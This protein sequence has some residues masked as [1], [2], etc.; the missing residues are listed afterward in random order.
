MAIFY[1]LLILSFALSCLFVAIQNEKQ[2]LLSLFLKG[3]ASIS[4]ICLGLYASFKTNLLVSTSGIMFIIGLIFCLFGDVLLA[5][6]EFKQ[7]N[8]YNIINSGSI[9]FA[10]AHLF[11]IIAM[12][13]QISGNGLYIAFCLLF[14]ILM[15]GVI[16]LIQKPMKLDYNKSTPVI[17]CYT[18]MLSTSLSISFASMIIKGFS[19]FSIIM[20]VGFVLFFV[21]D[22]ILSL[23]YFKENSKRSLYYYNLGTYYL[24]I[25]SI[26]LSFVLF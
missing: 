24:A 5:L 3:I 2:P 15:V 8:K 11:F 21:S 4:V 13:L 12:I 19:I 26:A 16:Y 25:I 17:L 23:I 6:L 22:L 14:S 9:S 10:L 18:F 7:N 1:V 20:F